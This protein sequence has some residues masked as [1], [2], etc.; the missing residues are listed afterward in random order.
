MAS[1]KKMKEV[2]ERQSRELGRLWNETG[3]PLEKA[4][5]LIRACN[6]TVV[7]VAFGKS[8]AVGAKLAATLRS[9]GR[10]ANL[11]NPVEA[12]HGEAASISSDDVAILI[13]SSGESDEI[14]RIIP[15]LKKKKVKLIALTPYERSNMARAADVVLKTVAPAD[16]TDN[17]ASYSS[18]LS[19]LAIGDLLALALLYEQDI[20][21]ERAAPI[22]PGAGEAIYTIEDLLAT[23][24]NNPVVRHDLIFRDALIELTSKGLGAIS[25]TGEDG[26]LAGII[27]DGD[28]RRLLQ[29]S[30]G[31]ITQLFLKN[32]DSVMTKNP[33]RISS[34]K[35]LSDA[36]NVMEDN[37]ITVLP[38]VNGN[39][40]PVGMLHLHDLIQLGMLVGA[41]GRTKSPGAAAKKS[42]AKK[43][44]KSK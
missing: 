29:R 17:Y 20:E 27:T 26:T 36:L 22:R 31:S 11:I 9:A 2:L 19:A 8:G 43:K 14:I 15:W 6:G 24:P 7:V 32:V 40:V 12:F 10:R 28:V 41:P 25:I 30:Q 16:A 5:D 37:A 35:T 33:K 4:L 3:K 13:S 34:N 23:R 39:S 42:A 21:H 18:C 38:V 1:M 44:P